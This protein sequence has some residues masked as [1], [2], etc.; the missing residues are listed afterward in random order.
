M[1]S[2]FSFST[3]AGEIARTVFF[4]DVFASAFAEA[5]FFAAAFLA[6]VFFTALF[7]AAALDATGLRVVF[8]AVAFAVSVFVS[9]EA[10]LVLAMSTSL[11][12]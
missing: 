10:A 4:A 8:F 9:A 12:V 7:A 6:V 3:V 2:A 5:G 11:L 1:F